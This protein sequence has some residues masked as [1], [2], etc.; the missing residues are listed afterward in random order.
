MAECN[1]GTGS[2][3]IIKQ[4]DAYAVQVSLTFNGEP[5][6]YSDLD[7][8][9]EIE[10]TFGE[11]APMRFKP[12]DIY[13]TTI[14]AFLVPLTQRQT[15]MLEDGKILVD[16]RV[17]FWGGDVVGVSRMVRVFVRE[18]LSWEIL[19]EKP[20]H[21]ITPPDPGDVLVLPLTVTANGTYTAPSGRAYS[22]VVVNVPQ[23]SGDVV[24]ASWH[25]CP[26]AVRN[27]LANVDYTG[28][29]YT[30]TEITDYAPSP[31]VIE[32]TKP[33]GK[34][35]DGV[36]YYNAAPNAD[37]PFASAN[38]A[39]TLNPLDQVRWINSQT[40]NM[41]DIGGWACDGGTV[42]YGILFRSGNLAAA[43][44]DLIVKQL[45]IHTELDLS[46]DGIPAY[47]DR[48]RFIEGVG[49]YYNI[50]ATAAWRTNLRGIF[51]TVKYGEPVV[52][53]CAMGADRTGT[54]ACILEGLLGVSQSNIDKD[55]ELTSFYALRA[56]N[57]N[58]QG[59]TA[60][61]AHLM[62]QIEALNGSTI[63]DKVVGF[64]LGLGFTVAE[65]NAFRHAMIDGN[66]GDITLP[67]YSVTNA[68]THCSSSNAATSVEYGGSY[69]ATITAAQGYML[70][71]ALVSIT[72]G[73]ADITATAYSNGTISIPSVTGNL[74]I[75][76]S[77]AAQATTYSVTNT[78]TGCLNSNGATSVLENASYTATI[79]ADSGYSL[80]GA[81]VQ[82]TMGGTDITSSAYSNGTISIASVNGNLVITVTAIGYKELFDYATA[83][84]NQRF[85]SS[86]S[87]TALDGNF[88]TDFIPVSGLA[89]ADP[90][91][92][93]IKDTTDATRFQAMGS[94][95]S[96]MYYKSDKT[97]IDRLMV[98]T[99]T[100]G[101]L[102]TKH[103]DSGGGIYVDINVLSNGSSP[104]PFD[105]SQVAYIRVCMAYSNGTEI[106]STA[107][108]ANV[109]IKSDQIL[110]T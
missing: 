40:L 99:A 48:M 5:I 78:L 91:R 7:L 13:N 26:E 17:Q 77:A 2:L 92:I 79:T 37:T 35:I 86:G 107:T 64:V 63:R 110:D 51:D 9:E 74:V 72:M 44:E 11:L 29:P 53:H 75:A 36:T 103:G 50:T 27:Y 24:R 108:L 106:P 96:V 59:G 67:T 95:E 83:T 89:S 81:T 70:T 34:T 33:I 62:A 38:A 49:V 19:P 87:Y 109:S 55:Y 60:D 14:G 80:T 23:G 6:V 100:S 52:F 98:S 69:S 93:H 42:R 76:I 84:I 47:G 20:Y 45:G 28:V 1:C 10:F 104:I 57:G 105:L 39:G 73:G 61:W 85:N 41:R 54:L 30:E 31:A 43:D 102:L 82:I 21:E 4:G 71:G 16:C 3:P 90:W 101:T 56:R 8:I 58:Y 46:D 12:K 94:N 32:N 68:L 88:C 97:V 25:Q 66:P 15:F 65:I 18:A 22:P